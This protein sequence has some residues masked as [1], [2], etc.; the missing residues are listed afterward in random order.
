[1]T[2]DEDVANKLKTEARRSGRAFRDVL[3]E[4][5][6]RGM[7]SQRLTRSTEPFR[8]VARDLGDLRPGVSI[9]SIA[10]LVE[11]LEGPQHR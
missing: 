6:R 7:A 10:D 3:N 11:R 5:L 1:V 2:L 8:V 4:A 9:D